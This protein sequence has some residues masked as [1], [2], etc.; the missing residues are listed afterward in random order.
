AADPAIAAAAAAED[1]AAALPARAE[2]ARLASGALFVV[3]TDRHGIRLAHPNPDRIHEP[4]STDPSEVLAGRDLI[5]VE[6]GTLGLSAR[7]K[8][9]LRDR[10]GAVVGEVSVGFRADEI[11]EYVWQQLGL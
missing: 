7:G 10:S 3:I 11:R 4:V 5:N 9:P 8:T 1:P 2:A 6:R